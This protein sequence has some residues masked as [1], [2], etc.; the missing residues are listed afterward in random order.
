[1]AARGLEPA[2][3]VLHPWIPFTSKHVFRE[4]TIDEPLPAILDEARGT[5]L[6][7]I[8]DLSGVMDY[9]SDTDADLLGGAR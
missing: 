9:G 8:R 2:G 4:G 6:L 7:A 3:E 5:H 1:L